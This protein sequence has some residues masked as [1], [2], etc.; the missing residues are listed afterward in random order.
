MGGAYM[1]GTDH[2]SDVRGRNASSL[3]AGS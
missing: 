2:T 1:Y 3:I